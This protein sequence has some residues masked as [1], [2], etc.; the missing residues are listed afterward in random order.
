MQEFYPT[1][2]LPAEGELGFQVAEVPDPGAE[3]HGLAE[4]IRAVVYEHDALHR[5]IKTRLPTSKGTYYQVQTLGVYRDPPFTQPDPQAPRWLPVGTLCPE[6]ELDHLAER[7]RD[8][9]LKHQDPNVIPA[10][11][12]S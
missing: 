2:V 1:D 12:A 3:F 8:W 9:L 10:P 11:P 5:L 7:V 6:G 4:T